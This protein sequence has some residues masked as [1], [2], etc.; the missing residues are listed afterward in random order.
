MQPDQSEDLTAALARARAPV[1]VH[2]RPAASPMLRLRTRPEAHRL[3]PPALTLALAERRGLANWRAQSEPYHAALAATQAIVAGTRRADE[4]DELTRRRLI[5]IEI[6]EALY[7]RPWPPPAIDEESRENLF[8]AIATGRGVMISCCHLGP[9]FLGAT[10]ICSLGVEL[11][12]TTG[13]WLLEPP[14]AGYWGRRVDRWIREIA[15]RGEHL[16]S[17]TGAFDVIR[18]LLE[19]GRLVKLFFDMPG[20]T[21]TSFLGKPV[22]LA[23]GS[24]RL[25]WMTGALVVPM[26]IHRSGHRGGLRF[27]TPIDS[28]AHD[29]HE[30]LHLALASI[31]ESAILEDPPGLEDPNRPGGWEH[32]ALPSGWLRPQDD[33][34]PASA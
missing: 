17:T 15:A 28:T 31:H 18:V 26:H 5:E 6:H 8:S 30:P 34:P 16:I 19:E 27:G 12:S 2:P 24:A 32:R 1:P 4:V 23:S 9:F 10:G 25:A 11:Y 22:M 21:R 14:A 33:S 3:I 13:P 29:G 20:G 7:W